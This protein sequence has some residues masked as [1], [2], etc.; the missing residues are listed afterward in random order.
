V[1]TYPGTAALIDQHS[2][3]VWVRPIADALSEMVTVK[4]VPERELR[5]YDSTDLSRPKRDRRISQPV[6]APA[7]VRA[8]P[9]PALSMAK[10]NSPLVA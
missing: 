2:I 8:C 10:W 1:E 4:V 3:A 9:P 5:G 6:S 7:A